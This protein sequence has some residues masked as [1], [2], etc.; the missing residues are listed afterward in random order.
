[1]SHCPIRDPPTV[2]PPEPNEDIDRLTQFFACILRVPRKNFLPGYDVLVKKN[3]FL[4]RPIVHRGN[5][6]SFSQYFVLKTKL[7]LIGGQCN[8]LKVYRICPTPLYDL[9]KWFK[10]GV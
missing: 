6:W 1:M 4:A 3:V 10:M 5:L 7:F 9:C 8:L 2:N